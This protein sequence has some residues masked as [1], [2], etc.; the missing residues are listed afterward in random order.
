MLQ[1]RK[2]MSH[3]CLQL[4]DWILS[5]IIQ[6]PYEYTTNRG[7][8]VQFFLLQYK[9]ITEICHYCQCSPFKDEDQQ[10]V[11]GPSIGSWCLSKSMTQR[12]K[13]G[14]KG[15]NLLDTL[16]T[17]RNF[18][19]S[20]HKKHCPDSERAITVCTFIMTYLMYDITKYQIFCQIREQDTQHEAKQWNQTYRHL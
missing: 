4:C 14:P 7:K 16:L 12:W 13:D 3:L 20:T 8:E 2:S 15:L 9:P 19:L 17:W 18:T 10:L 11:W 5:G 6:L 1:P